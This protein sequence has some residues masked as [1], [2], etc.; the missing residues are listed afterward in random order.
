MA[1]PRDR[2]KARRCNDETFDLFP[3]LKGRFQRQ[4]QYPCYRAS[5]IDH[6]EAN[7]AG[8]TFCCEAAKTG[9][10]APPAMFADESFKKRSVLKAN[11]ALLNL[12][13]FSA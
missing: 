4:T 12:F 11:R 3:Q 10:Q 13:L 1:A 8:A 6:I 9:R 5:I 2:R 7:L